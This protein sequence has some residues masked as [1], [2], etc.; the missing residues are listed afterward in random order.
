MKTKIFSM[1]ALS[2]LLLGTSCSNDELNEPTNGQPTTATFSVQL[3]TSIGSRKVAANGPRKVFADGTKAT[4]LKYMVYEDGNTTTPII[5]DSTA[6]N[7]T[8][9][10]PLQLT[11]G[12]EYKIVFWAANASAPYTLSDNGS[13]KVNYEGMKA[14][15]ESLDAFY[16]CIDYTAGADGD[17][18]VKLNRPFAQLNVGTNDTTAAVNTGFKLD[19]AKTTVVVKGIADQI[20]LLTGAVTGDAEAKITFASN[21]IPVK[22]KF[23]KAG[24]KYL[25][26]DYLLVGKSEKSAVDVD[27]TINDGTNNITR[28]FT[29]VPVQ[30]NYR[31]NIYGSLLTSTSDMNVEINPAFAGEDYGSVYGAKLVSNNDELKTALATDG[32]VVQLAM[33]TT[34]TLPTSVANNT[35]IYGNRGAVINMTGAV[36]YHGKN[37]TFE[38]VTLQMPGGNYIGIQHANSVK[39]INS[40]IKGMIFSYATDAEFIGCT[41]EQ[42]AVDYNI[43]TYGSKNITFTNCKFNCNGKAVLIYS[44][45]KTLVQKATFNNCKFTTLQGVNSHSGSGIAAIEVDSSLGPNYDV[46]INGCTANKLFNWNS[47]I[48]HVKKGENA[49]IWVDGKQ[50]VKSSK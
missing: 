22:E 49:N 47:T 19:D 25:S 32:A 39:F 11:T 27:W 31:T 5:K 34:Y 30:G 50:V 4:K 24:Y 14:N 46:Y 38:D 42:D 8:A 13:V 40:V 20:D 28:T 16:N 2:A 18:T 15:D 7:I 17:N 35:K 6:I 33:N 41:F 26:M 23:P 3:P 43:W 44:E 36:A 45:D 1:M 9:T 12:K 10:V 21:A 48:Y 29:N 37:I